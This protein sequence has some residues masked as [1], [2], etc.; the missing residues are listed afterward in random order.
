MLRHDVD[1]PTAMEEVSPMLTLPSVPSGETLPS[2]SF[3]LPIR[4]LLE[5][6]ALPIE[7]LAEIALR[8]G[9]ASTPIYRVHR[10]F[11]RRL[12]SQFRAL[13]TA[14]SL[15]EGEGS[16][17]WGHYERDFSL[18]GLVVLD[19]FVG[20]GTSVVEASRCGAK[21]I[22]FDVDPVATAV[23]RFELAAAHHN[24]QSVEEL[25]EPFT[26]LAATMAPYHT[27]L[28]ADGRSVPVLHH[29]WVEV[30]SCADC[31]TE[32][33]L[34]PHYRLAYDT[35]R[36]VQW[37]F[38][39]ACHE[40][41]ELPLAQE[42]LHCQCGAETQILHGTLKRSIRCPKCASKWEVSR[43]GRTEGSPPRWKLFAQEYLDGEGSRPKRR[44]KRA[45]PLDQQTYDRA[46]ANFDA[47]TP[48]ALARVPERLI[49]IEGRSDDR[50]I[51][52]GFTQYK[53]LF[54]TRQLLH[55]AN[56]G[57]AIAQMS[58]EKRHFYAMAFTE[59]LTSNCMYA[60]YAF[61]YRRLSPLF[62][63]HAY[64]HITRPVELNPW[65]LGTGRGTFPNAIQKL[66][67]AVKFAKQPM[68]YT[69]LGLAN[70][71]RPI[72]PGDGKVAVEASVVLEG[73][74]NAAVV[75]HSSTSLQGLGN[76][77]VDLVLTDP[78][79]F[80]NVS[81]S[82]LSDFYLAWQ[83]TL[84]VAIPP[85][86]DVT[87][88][89]PLRANL[90]LTKRSADAIKE[91]R[92]RLTS[93]FQECHRVLRREGVFVF[94]YHHRAPEAWA[95]LGEALA[96]SGF[97]CTAVVPLRGEGQNGMHDFEG[98]LK[99]DA[100]LVCRPCPKQGIVATPCEEVTVS[101]DDLTRCVEQAEEYRYRL[102]HKPRI[103]FQDQDALNFVR[104]LLA[105]KARAVPADDHRI[106]LSQALRDVTL[107]KQVT[108]D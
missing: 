43:R 48:G 82:E 92:D 42:S 21:V 84:G 99:W 59:H 77:T 73:A 106:T 74:A 80:D 97:T 20:G 30:T 88:S 91:Y 49:P 31:D 107:K 100:V 29:F 54:N 68:S 98:T 63:M 78:P 70:P 55:L 33:E 62:S 25:L 61:G 81:Y 40:V 41:H 19:P 56:L 28:L 4:T 51:I 13:L 22:G 89:A 94:T 85:Y 9:Q 12:G 79:Y 45:D 58:P 90:A 105:A 38:C 32:F 23:T 47:L 76:G 6:G 1:R 57:D 8:E 39:H 75:A 86:D 65:L 10:W 64:R 52:H 27:T 103:G 2:Q 72:G 44:F 102:L 95:A 46:V 7:E 16:N 14:L 60:S 93:I 66:V 15:P 3:R 35:A 67:R 101:L 36:S 53:E 34:H 71:T 50:P 11:A 108:D 87:R 96:W 26:D 37:A 5:E 17:F 69:R 24:S 18:D 104:A 83:Q